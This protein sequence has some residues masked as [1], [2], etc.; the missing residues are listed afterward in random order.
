MRTR[1]T[2]PLA[3]SATGSLCATVDKHSLFVWRTGTDVH[4]P[5]N[6]T[7]TKPYTVRP[8]GRFSPLLVTLW[9]SL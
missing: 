8:S 4:Q 7:H 9:S 2:G 1:S 3:L 6:L 5:L